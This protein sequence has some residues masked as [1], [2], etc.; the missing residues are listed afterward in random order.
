MFSEILIYLYIL[1]WIAMKLYRT[2][3]IRQVSSPGIQ[4]NAFCHNAK[5]KNK[6]SVMEEHD[7][8]FKN[9]SPNSPDLISIERHWEVMDKQV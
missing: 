9:E 6:K 4:D 8:D 5:K 7:K 2:V 1:I 3:G